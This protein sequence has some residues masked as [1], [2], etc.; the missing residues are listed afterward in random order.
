MGSFGVQ[1]LVSTIKLAPY[2]MSEMIRIR[3]SSVAPV[4]K[5]DGTLDSAEVGNMQPVQ[6]M[7]GL[8]HNVYANPLDPSVAVQ[9]R[10]VIPRKAKYK[11]KKKKQ[12]ANPGEIRASNH[13]NNPPSVANKAP[14]PLNTRRREL[15]SEFEAAGVPRPSKRARIF[16]NGKS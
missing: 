6:Y 4:G 16:K 8:S 14:N 2:D 3:S 11:P 1:Y 9:P 7:S 12:Q 13:G 15:N 10:V 5:H